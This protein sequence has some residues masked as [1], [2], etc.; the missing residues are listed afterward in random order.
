MRLGSLEG[1]GSETHTKP[2]EESVRKMENRKGRPPL[3]TNIFY[4]INPNH[5]LGTPL[6]D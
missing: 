6:L 1:Q 5:I 3:M 2:K 4:N